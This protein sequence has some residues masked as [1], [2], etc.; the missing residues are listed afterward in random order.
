MVYRRFAD[1]RGNM[2]T[3]DDV[4]SLLAR[5]A[6]GMSPTELSRLTGG[7]VIPNTADLYQKGTA[8]FAEF[9]KPKTIMALTDALRLGHDDDVLLAFARSCGLR[10][11]EGEPLV[12][13][14][15]RAQAQLG[16]LDAYPA[17]SAALGRAV[18]AM[19][20]VVHQLR[21]GE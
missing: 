10:V 3:G 21:A 12:V 5:Y 7:V 20:D 2:A 1:E 6:P 4:P 16:D 11:R 14:D 19:A 9:P 13:R 8:R 17:L 15:V 18:G